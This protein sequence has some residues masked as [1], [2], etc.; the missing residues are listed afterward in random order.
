MI[1]YVNECKQCAECKNCGAKRRPKLICEE[2]AS[3][4]A[5]LYEV[6]DT[7]MCHDCIAEILQDYSTVKLDENGREREVYYVGDTEY[8]SVAEFESTLEQE[9]LEDY[10]D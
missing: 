2:C 10:I 8:L 6:D 4:V 5:V 7:M 3:H 9:T 1:S